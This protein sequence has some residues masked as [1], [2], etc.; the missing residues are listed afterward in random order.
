MT[1]DT[2]SRGVLWM[3]LPAALVVGLAV[4]DLANG[5]RDE[6]AELERLG[7]LHL[8]RLAGLR[9]DVLLRLRRHRLALRSEVGGVDVAVGQEDRHAILGLA[10]RELELLE[11]AAEA[12]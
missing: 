4:G 9:S 6:I 3:H 12:C 1:S 8:L 11:E 5:L 7:R 2:G 10:F